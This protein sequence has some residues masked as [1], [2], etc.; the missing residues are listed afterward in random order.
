MMLFVVADSCST[1]EQLDDFVDSLQK[2][3]QRSRYQL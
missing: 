2:V 3:A 1:F